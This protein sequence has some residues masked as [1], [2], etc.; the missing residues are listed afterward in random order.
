MEASSDELLKGTISWLSYNGG[1]ISI[2]DGV[3]VFKIHAGDHY[4]KINPEAVLSAEELAKAARFSHQESRENY[5]V[6][7]YFLRTLLSQFM[8]IPHSALVFQLKA[9]KKPAID[10]LFFNVSH[11]KDLITIAFSATEIGI[12][13]EYID[14]YFNYT[15]VADFCFSAEEKTMVSKAPLSVLTF[16]LLWTRKEA[17]VKATGEG[18]VEQLQEVPSRSASVFRNGT[19]YKID[20]FYA[21]ETHLLSIANSTESLAVKFWSVPATSF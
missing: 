8:G 15:E 1:P 18:I 14:P 6:R 11:S 7:K 2:K 13:L 19:H 3:H 4:K 10:G 21:E 12:D 17:I 16:Y 9:N 5:V 20:S